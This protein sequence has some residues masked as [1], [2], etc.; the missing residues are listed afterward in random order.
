MD[1]IGVWVKRLDGIW[2]SLN[3]QQKPFLKIDLMFI[4]Y[5]DVGEIACICKALKQYRKRIRSPRSLKKM[6]ELIGGFS[7]KA[8]LLRVQ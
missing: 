5:L 4:R 1:N 2:K 3:L 6:D 8:I 7:W